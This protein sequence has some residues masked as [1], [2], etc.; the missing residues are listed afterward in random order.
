MR[1][2]RCIGRVGGYLLAV[3]IWVVAR[4]T[5]RTRLLV[6]HNDS[7]LVV[8]GWL[9][10]GGWLAPGGGIQR[11][12]SPE[13][14]AVRELCEE[15]G[16]RARPQDL[17]SLGKMKQTRG[18]V[19]PFYAFLLELSAEPKLTIPRHEINVARWVNID[20]LDQL[21]VHQHISL[22]L[23]AWRAGR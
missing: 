17:Q 10:T 11:G 12:E 16:I 3:P 13:S 5:T 14:A 21:R 7:I 15:T 4:F 19:Y 8:Q 2:W 6:V 23:S 22:L 20:Q 9:G 1:L 18:Y